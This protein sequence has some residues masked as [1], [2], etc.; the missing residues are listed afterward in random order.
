MI[1]WILFLPIMLVEAAMLVVCT[2]FGVATM[3]LFP[4]LTTRASSRAEMYKGLPA[5][6]VKA[7]ERES[8]IFKT[9]GFILMALVLFGWYCDATKT[10]PSPTTTI[11]TPTPTS[12]NKRVAERS[13][14]TAVLA[15]VLILCTALFAVQVVV[16]GHTEWGKKFQLE[17]PNKEIASWQK[18]P[19]WLKIFFAVFMLS[20]GALVIILSTVI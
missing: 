14:R 1:I 3:H 2:I 20:A 7:L 18:E 8:A 17:T 6:T 11:S 13:T 5:D 9:I 19:L 15:T 16:L 10:D 4:W 12:Y